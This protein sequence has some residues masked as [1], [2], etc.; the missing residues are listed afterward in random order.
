MKDIPVSATIKACDKYL[1]CNQLPLI[2]SKTLVGDIFCHLN[3]SSVHYSVCDIA[4]RRD[5]IAN[6]LYLSIKFVSLFTIVSVPQDS[7]FIWEGGELG[8]RIWRLVQF[9]YFIRACDKIHI[10]MCTIITSISFITTSNLKGK[11]PKKIKAGEVPLLVLSR[12]QLILRQLS[13]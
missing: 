12:Q 4:K 6:F 9:L 11:V 5:L 10:G 8:R 7:K 3:L 1:L 2:A 13:R